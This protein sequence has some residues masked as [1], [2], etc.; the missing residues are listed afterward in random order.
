M[1]LASSKVPP[2]RPSSILIQHR[3][4]EETFHEFMEGIQNNNNETAGID[5]KLQTNEEAI[6]EGKESNTDPHGAH[7]QIGESI[8]EINLPSYADF[9]EKLSNEM[10]PGG[11][12]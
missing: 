7:F 2:S 8:E 9:I 4:G 11:G 5:F 10:S 1:G 12:L 3:W 6:T